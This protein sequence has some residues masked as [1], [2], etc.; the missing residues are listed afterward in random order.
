MKDSD[1]TKKEMPLV[2]FSSNTTYAVGAVVLQ[3]MVI[4]SIIMKNFVVIDITAYYNPIL[5][6]SCINKM[7]AIPSTYH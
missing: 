3:V 7:K 5:E 6:R 1:I 4:G 2:G